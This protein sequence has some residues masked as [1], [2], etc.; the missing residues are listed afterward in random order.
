MATARVDFQDG[1]ETGD[2]TG[3]SGGE[4]D[5]GTYLDVV[6]YST[7]AGI[8]GMPMPYSGAYCSRWIVAG[9]SSTADAIY[10]EADIDCAATK[11]SWVKFNVWIDP[12][13][14]APGTKA[15]T[16]YK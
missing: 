14:Y 6:H 16:M 4:T 15:Q 3:W 2:A 11:V 10:T 1:F 9:A 8:S 12:D 5:T 7:L 13:E